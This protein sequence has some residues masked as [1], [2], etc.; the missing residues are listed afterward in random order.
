MRIGIA[1]R[2]LGLPAS[3]VKE[4]IHQLCKGLASVALQHDLFI[5]YSDVGQ[6]LEF[7]K[8]NVHEHV[9]PSRSKLVWDNVL[10]P[11]QLRTDRVDITIYPKCTSP[12]IYPGMSA[13][14]VHDM[15]YFVPELK[16]YR[17]LDTWY[18]KVMMPRSLKA[19]DVV[20]AVSHFTKTE[21][22][23]LL[24]NIDPVKISVTHEA[25]REGFGTVRTG[26]L[27]AHFNLP[28]KPLVFLS[29][30]ITPR[31]NIS[32]LLQALSL[33]KDEIPHH[34]VL[35]GGQSWG[36]DP[37]QTRLLG[38]GLTSRVHRLGFVSESELAGLYSEADFYVMP[39]LYE[40]FS[41]TL[42]EAMA[43]GCPVTCSNVASHP[44]VVGD[45]A[46]LFD[47]YSVA[48]IAAA[49]KRMATDDTLREDLRLRGLERVKHFSWEKCAGETLAAIEAAY[50]KKTTRMRD[51]G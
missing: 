25:V 31:K 50:A 51:K 9:L 5:Y 19:G 12:L 15:G 32:R 10:L 33:V 18:M 29:T 7:G 43:A 11:L 44:E 37:V 23:R 26:E 6:K 49:M 27:K 36:E 24:P 20:L 3:G 48:D 35:T 8:V 4:Y 14:T 1:A 45:A 30:A 42:L 41:L 17:A 47:P 13:V 46:L 39:S 16:A 28:D 22:C 2:G 38:H 40:G 21:I 34:F